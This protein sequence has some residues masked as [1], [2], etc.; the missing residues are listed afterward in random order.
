[1]IEVTYLILNLLSTLLI[2]LFSL[3]SFEGVAYLECSII[4]PE[5][6]LSSVIGELRPS[7]EKAF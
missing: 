4:T 1:M 5:L 6:L 7:L 2:S 3:K